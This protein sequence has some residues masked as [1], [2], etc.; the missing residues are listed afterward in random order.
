MIL[1]CQQISLAFGTEVIL[2]KISFHIEDHEKTAIVGINGAG[3]STLLKII[4]GELTPDSGEVIISRGKTIGYLAQ[5]QDIHSESTIY[6]EMMKVRENVVR[7][8]DKLRQ[9]ELDMKQADE[10]K[11]P[12]MYAAYDRLNHAF[13]QEN[14]YALQSEVTGVL[15]GLGFSEEDFNKKVS[16]LSGGQ[17]TRISLGRLLLTKPDIILLD[18]PT[19][20]LDMKTKDILK[21]ALLDFDGTLIVVSHDRDFLDGLVTK[22]YEF[23]N[24]Q[25]KE[26]LS[27]IYE[28]LEKKKMESLREL[29]R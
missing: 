14:G 7:I 13:E 6:E 2:D 16:S 20:H 1:S 24:K 22:V 4:M 17:K 21:Q 27:G 18:E 26:H 28:F 12:E 11:L 9:L 19:N 15:K 8:Y 25:V 10:D 23:G 3:K 5:H 29:E